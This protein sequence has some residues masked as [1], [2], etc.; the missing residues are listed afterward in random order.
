MCIFYHL[1]DEFKRAVKIYRLPGPPFSTSV[2]LGC[3]LY[4]PIASRGFYT[5]DLCGYMFGIISF[6]WLR[7]IQVAQLTQKSQQMYFTL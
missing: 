4:W 6:D 7:N 1:G 2:F 3:D 5:C